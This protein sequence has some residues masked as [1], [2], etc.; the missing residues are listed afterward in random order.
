MGNR[1][2]VVMIT[3]AERIKAD[4]IRLDFKYV[5]FVTE[6]NWTAH[7]YKV[8]LRRKGRQ[9]TLD[10]RM[11]SGTTDDPDALNVL[12]CILSDT[13][14]YLNSTGFPDWADEYGYDIQNPDSRRKAQKIYNSV[15]RQAKRAEQ[16]FQADFMRYVDQTDWQI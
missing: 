12:Y 8:T 4:R 1:N 5:D 9:W 15:K 6:D 3:L 11:G 2:G 10:F 13:S 7:K 14:G 16:F